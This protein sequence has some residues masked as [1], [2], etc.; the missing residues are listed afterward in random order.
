MT[1]LALVFGVTVGVFTMGLFNGRS[2]EKGYA[3]GQKIIY[4]RKGEV[5]K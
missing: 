4:I 2:Y 1:I 3:D 5:P